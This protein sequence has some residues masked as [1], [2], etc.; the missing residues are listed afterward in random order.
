MAEEG[1]MYCGEGW[2]T[3]VCREEVCLGEEVNLVVHDILEREG[4]WEHLGVLGGLC[5]SPSHSPNPFCFLF[6]LEI[7]LLPDCF[8][9]WHGRH[10]GCEWGPLGDASRFSVDVV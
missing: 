1:L 6:Q 5:H 7:H 4:I 2:A 8:H 9:C 10:R 3:D